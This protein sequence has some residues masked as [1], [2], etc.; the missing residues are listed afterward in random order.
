MMGR[1]N[2]LGSVRA[3]PRDLRLLFLA[4]FLWTF[5]LGVYNYI[6]SLYLT[7]L[8]ANP[9]QVGVVSSIGFVSA[10]VSMIPGGVLANKYD[11]KILLIIGWAMSI[12]CPVLFYY[13][14]T[15]PEVIPGLVILQ[16]SAFNLP[17]M[18]AFIGELADKT[19]VSSA[20]GASTLLRH[21]A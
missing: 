18:N 1:L 16:L 2:L 20:F 9:E 7:Q 17:A 21:W 11:A 3:L 6:W 5:G 12:P 19:R 4:L 8:N 10:A 15:W 13:A 14:R